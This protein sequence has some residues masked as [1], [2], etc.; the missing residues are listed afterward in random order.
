MKILFVTLHNPFDLGGGSFA[1]HAYLRALSDIADG[2]IDICLACHCN[3]ND[4]NIRYSNL[5]KVGERSQ[6]SRLMSVFTGELSRYTKYVK[7]LLRRTDDYDYCVFDTSYVGGSLVKYVNSKGIKTITIHHNYQ[8]EYFADNTPSLLKRKLFLHHVVSN[9]K[10]TYLYSDYNLFLTESDMLKFKQEYGV[11][12]GAN[13]LLGV[14]EF[15]DHHR[16]SIVKQKDESLTFAIT[17][18]FCD[19]QAVDGIKYFF[20]ELYQYLP[21]DCKIIV[22]G[23]NPSDEVIQLCASHHNVELIPNPKDMSAI[24]SKADVY[25]CPTR[26]G[27]GLKLRV[28]DGLKLGLPVVT[29]ACSARG[30]DMFHNSSYFHVFTSQQEFKEK[31]NKI[32]AMEIDKHEVIDLYAETFSYN[33]GL[34]RLKKILICK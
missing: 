3:Y 4:P 30:Y 19:Y 21:V 9:E 12:K 29:H 2:N 22:S 13:H 34:D 25:I 7:N 16:P 10:R 5:F 11:N 32:T 27:G 1:S 15:A 14:F 17:G 23:R 28:M 18:S 20:K 8:P 24:I 26:I 6:F 31:I 33:A